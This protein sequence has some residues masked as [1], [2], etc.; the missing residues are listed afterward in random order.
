MEPRSISTF[1]ASGVFSEVLPA[2]VPAEM[3][4]EAD[5]PAKKPKLTEDTPPED[6]PAELV[7]IRKDPGVA[8]RSRTAAR[9]RAE[10]FVGYGHS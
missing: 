4:Y 2:G 10:G 5:V 7:A 1:V 8:H 3:D 9:P 6:M